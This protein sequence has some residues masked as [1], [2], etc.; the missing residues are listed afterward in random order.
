MTEIDQGAVAGDRVENGVVVEVHGDGPTQVDIKQ[1]SRLKIL[2]A[3]IE[4]LRNQEQKCW[5]DIS[6]TQKQ[7]EVNELGEAV[8]A[9]SAVIAEQVHEDLIHNFEEKRQKVAEVR[10]DLAANKGAH[11][12]LLLE[13]AR[14]VGEIVRD[15]K[16][17]DEEE[18][19][20]FKEQQV[21]DK[22]ERALVVQSHREIQRERR[23]IEKHLIEEDRR[24]EKEKRYHSVLQDVES[25]NSEIEEAER[26]EMEAL[27]KLQHSQQMRDQFLHQSLHSI[28]DG[29]APPLSARIHS[30]RSAR[31]SGATFGAAPLFSIRILRGAP[32]LA[33]ATQRS[34]LLRRGA[35]VVGLGAR[36][37]Y[38]ETESFRQARTGVYA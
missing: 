26:L 25:L 34:R 7:A 24:R 14:Q 31:G 13:E 15:Q 4:R 2:H 9:T 32:G 5:K 29:R 8:R 3:R 28:A 30:A 19:R 16:Q 21:E 20:F 12:E 33:E 27:E 11:K 23:E 38:T 35:E 22:R 1:L 18:L 37:Q 10:A 6:R 36:E 17:R